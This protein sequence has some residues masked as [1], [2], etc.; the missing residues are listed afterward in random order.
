MLAAASLIA[1]VPTADLPR[2]R[3]FYAEV[4]GLSIT[5]ESPFACVF[6][7]GGVMLR[8][9]PARKVAKTSYTVLGWKVGDID[10]TVRRLAG[11]GVAFTRYRGMP[12][13]ELGVWTAP[14]GDRVAWFQDPDGNL[15]SLT[16]FAGPATA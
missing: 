10:D 5:D 1:F 12:Q 8:V 13:D 6:D 7:A 15:L 4:L 14:G 16:Q 11:R 9:A 3:A 2:A